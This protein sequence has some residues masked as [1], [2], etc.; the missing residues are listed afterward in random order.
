ML[1]AIILSYCLDLV[2]TRVK[3]TVYLRASI[4]GGACF[5]DGWARK[6]I[7]QYLLLLPNILNRLV[8]FNGLNFKVKEQKEQ[9]LKNCMF[10]GL[11]SCAGSLTI[12]Q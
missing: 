4:S 2:C 1:L 3:Y 7:S 11:E 5:L 10:T 8:I 12:S 6:K 9:R